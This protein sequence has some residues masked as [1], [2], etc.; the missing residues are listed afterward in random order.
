MAAIVRSKLSKTMVKFIKDLRDA[1]F[2]S[3]PYMEES[4]PRKMVQLLRRAM[5]W[6]SHKNLEYLCEYLGA[7]ADERCNT[8]EGCK[9]IIKEDLDY[10]RSKY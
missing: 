7:E 1:E 10:W 6:K 3:G 2:R 4:D 9:L 8:V 5:S